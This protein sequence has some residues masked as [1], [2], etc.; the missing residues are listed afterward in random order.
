MPAAAREMNDCRQPRKYN[1][2]C[3]SGIR[4]A[5]SMCVHIHVIFSSLC[6]CIHYS[7]LV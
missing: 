4:D 3:Q 7:D 6:V 1:K 5:N 2:M